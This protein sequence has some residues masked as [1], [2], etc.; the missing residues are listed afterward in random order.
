MWL[1]IMVAS[2]ACCFGEQCISRERM[3]GRSDVTNPH[4]LTAFAISSNRS[5]VQNVWPTK[6]GTAASRVNGKV[7]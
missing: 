7:E 1:I 5:T 3:I 2:C 6:S 4:C